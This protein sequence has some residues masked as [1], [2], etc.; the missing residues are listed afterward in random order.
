MS[1]LVGTSVTFDILPTA[2]IVNCAILPE[3][4]YVPGDTPVCSKSKVTS[5]ASPPPVKPVPA[6][7]P[8]ISPCV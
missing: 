3:S 6:I 4:P 5:P 8:V 2:S 7:T 1:P